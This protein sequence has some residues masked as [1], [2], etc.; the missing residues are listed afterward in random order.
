MSTTTAT[1]AKPINYK[2]VYF[3]HATLDKVT[4]NPTYNNLQYL[5]KQVKA[6]SAYVTSTLGGDRQGNLVVVTNAITYACLAPGNPF[7]RPVQTAAL[8]DNN[9]GAAAEITEN[10]RSHN[11]AITHFH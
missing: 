2:E 7:V 6:N 5:Y 3:N 1:A 8:G 11:L 10:L 9:T 4:R